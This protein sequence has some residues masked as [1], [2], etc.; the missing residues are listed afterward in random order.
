VVVV[1]VV[2]VVASVV[3]VGGGWR[4]G[5]QT[6]DP[7]FIPRVAKDILGLVPHG[8]IGNR[9]SPA[10]PLV[11]L[12]ARVRFITRGVARAAGDLRAWFVGQLEKYMLRPN[13]PTARALRVL[14]LPPP[15]KQLLLVINCECVDSSV[16]ECALT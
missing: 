15:D 11:P 16:E 7:F 10:P 8:E 6:N 9:R 14:P 1:V 2:V 4:V 3:V 5:D 12:P 13:E